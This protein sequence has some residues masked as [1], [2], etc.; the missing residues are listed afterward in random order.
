MQAVLRRRGFDPARVTFVRDLSTPDAVA[1]FCAGKA[2]FLEH[3]PPVVDELIADGV[4]HLVASMGE[5]TGPV[6]FSSYRATPETLG[7]ERD[8][9]GRFVGGLYRA[10][11]WMAAATATE[12]AAVVAP[13]FDDIDAGVR[14]RVVERYLRQ[15]TWV[16][17]PALTRVGFET[18]QE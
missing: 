16:G 9:V 1:A 14:A 13:A 11:R 10:Q 17:D 7:R 12:I 3:G 18:L 4:G 8:V 15:A 2:D 6:P 5:A